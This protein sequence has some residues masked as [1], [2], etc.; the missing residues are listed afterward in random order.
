M[1]YRRQNNEAIAGLACVGITALIVVVFWAGI[2]F[3]ALH[4]VGKLW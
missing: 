1:N 3:V 4:F 2:I